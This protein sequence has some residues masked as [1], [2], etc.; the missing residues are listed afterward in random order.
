MLTVGSGGYTWRQVA[1]MQPGTQL[2]NNVV[3]WANTLRDRGGSPLLSY[4]HEPEQSSR[5]GLGGAEDF[6]DAFRKV[7]SVMRA[8]GATN[9][10]YTWHMT[11][12]S[13]RASPSSSSYA[14][15]W[16]PGD[17][18]VDIVGPD[19]YNWFTCGEG[20]GKWLQLG[21]LVQP[22]IDFAK[23]HGKKLAI[24]EFAS[25]IDGRRTDWIQQAHQ[26][27]E[28]NRGTV[29]AA[30]YFQYHPTNKANSDCVWALQRDSE[31]NAFETMVR[32]SAFSH[33]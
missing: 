17:A 30:F 2:Y 5:S 24:P 25:Y 22:A 28:A 13:F 4:S 10:R 6:K 8:H 9:V 1:N 15:K 32:D 26:F 33:Q 29:V 21:E 12:W 27:L 11:G 3:R 18:Y 14:A 16:Y 31:Y 7:V 23:A 20:M 19:E